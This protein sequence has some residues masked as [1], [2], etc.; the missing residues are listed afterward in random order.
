LVLVVEDNEDLREYISDILTPFH[1][2]ITASNGLQ[3]ERMAFEHIPDL[4]VTDVMMPK[5]DGYELCHSLKRNTKTSHIPIVMLTAKA[6][7]SNKMAGFT[8]GADVYLTKPFDAEELLL[9]IRNLIE[10]R[11]RIWDHFKALDMLLVDDLE[12]SSVE[13]QFLQKVMMVIKKNLDNELFAVDDIAREVGF[14]RSQL[15]RKLKALTDKSPQQLIAEIRLNEAYRL[16]ENKTGSVS[17]VAY[18]VGYT[19]MS[20]FAKTFKEKF[21]LL[22][23]KI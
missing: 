17:E 20:Y 15:H 18:S 6:G 1:R 23:S 19:N 14:S 3:G 11:K 21:G 13:D 2:I 7:K 10:A 22:P 8:Q 12:V 5:K 4:V 9:R 16:L